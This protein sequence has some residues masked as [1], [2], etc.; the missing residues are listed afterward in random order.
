M[1]GDG[2][3]S[4]RPAPKEIADWSDMADERVFRLRFAVVFN[5]LAPAI[6]RAR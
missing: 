2:E 6:Y 4:N 1:T 3:E 5:D